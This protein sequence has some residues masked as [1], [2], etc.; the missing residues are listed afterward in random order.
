MVF[1]RRLEV[2]KGKVCPLTRPPAHAILARHWIPS[3]TTILGPSH[4]PSVSVHVLK[5]QLLATVPFERDTPLS[6]IERDTFGRSVI[7]SIQIPV[8]VEKIGES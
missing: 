8:S 4:F 7:K 1:H 5:Y 2:V 6:D 3:S